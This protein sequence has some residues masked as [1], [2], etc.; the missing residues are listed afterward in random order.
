MIEDIKDLKLQE[1]K[2][3]FKEEDVDALIVEHLGT[4]L[5]NMKEAICKFVNEK[6][7]ELTHDFN[8]IAPHGKY[9]ELIEDND[10]MA[11]FLKKDASNPEFWKI[12]SISPVTD[13]P[14]LNFCFVCTAVDDGEEFKGYVFVSKSGVIRHA[15]AQNEI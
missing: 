6:A 8:N 15:F 11:E 13:K 10:G 1:L 9:D 4:P 3:D 7:E 14:M 5:L 12:Q 2:D